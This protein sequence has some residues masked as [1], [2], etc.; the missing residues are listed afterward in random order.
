MYQKDYIL[1]LI[2]EMTKFLAVLFGLMKKGDFQKASEH[3]E[4]SYYELLKKDAAY[5]RSIPEDNLTYDLIEKHNYTNGH[6]EILAELF[7]A[8]AEIYDAKGDKTGNLSY[9]QKSLMIFRFIDNE[10]R[11]YSQERLD[12]MSRIESRIRQLESN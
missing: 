10:Y 12:K 1:R 6:L 9:S 3:L 2:E 8:E 11:T 5:F 4:K 7:N